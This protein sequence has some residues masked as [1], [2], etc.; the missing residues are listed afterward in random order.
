MGSFIGAAKTG[1]FIE[2]TQKE[3][4]VEGK[5]VLLAKAGTLYYAFDKFCPHLKGDLSKGK[6]E[7][8]II[9]CPLQGSQ[10]DIRDGKPI[11]WLKEP[12]SS[13]TVKNTLH[14]PTSLK[15]YNVKIEGDNILIE[16]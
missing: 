13:A 2:V 11:R 9:T 14:P 4:I 15:V 3:I 7:G 12:V 5:E 10:F 16:V 8:T 6:L 1:E